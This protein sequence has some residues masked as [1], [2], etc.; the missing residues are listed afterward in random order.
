MDEEPLI[1]FDVAAQALVFAPRVGHELLGVVREVMQTH[2]AVL[3]DGVFNASLHADELAK[4]YTYETSEMGNGAGQGA[5]GD[6]LVFAE[7][8]R[9]LRGSR[10]EWWIPMTQALTQPGVAGQVE[11][12]IQPRGGA[13]A[14]EQ[15]AILGQRIAAHEGNREHPW[16][17]RSYGRR[18]SSRAKRELLDQSRRIIRSSFL[19]RSCFVPQNERNHPHSCR[20]STSAVLIHGVQSESGGSGGTAAAARLPQRDHQAA[21]P[22]QLF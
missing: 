7:S 9:H 12:Q 19:L 15:G 5:P 16:W 13:A 11:A 1:H 17:A 21:R 20:M 2:V 6:S 3:V 4:V 14:G 8:V 18:G 10:L 22:S